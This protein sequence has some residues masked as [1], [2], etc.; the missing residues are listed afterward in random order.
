LTPR[1][2]QLAVALAALAAAL[3][4][5][6]GI[7]VA[8]V[9]ATLG[10]A[11]RSVVAPVLLAR[12]AVAAFAAMLLIFLAALVFR[13]LF[14]RY[15]DAPAELLDQVRV[16]M[17]G[18]I[19]RELPERGSSANRGLAQAIAMLL[20]ERNRLRDDMARRVAEA[21]HDI[22]QER[23]RL[24]ALMSELEQS[25]VVCNLEGRILLY[26]NGARELF[27]T[28]ADS[29]VHGSPTGLI[30]LGRSIHA[31]ID[32]EIIAHALHGILS[33]LRDGARSPSSEF[34]T[35]TAAGHLLRVRMTAVPA[36]DG[37]GAGGHSG[38]PAGDPEG[39]LD[40]FVLMIDD[41]TRTFELDSQRDDLL[42]R[43]TEG[44]RASLANLQAAVEMLEL[45]DLDAP[46][47]ER[48]IAVI[49]EEVISL[50]GRVQA[51]AADVALETSTR[52]PLEDMR[53]TEF[54]AA[55]GRHIEA[56]QR[57]VR[58]EAG[59]VDP[60]LWLRVDSFAL[61]QALGYLAGRLHRDC[62]VRTLRLRITA[63]RPRVRLDLAWSGAVPASTSIASWQGDAMRTAGGRLPISVSDVVGRH[64][65]EFWFEREPAG[66]GGL[67]RFLLPLAD[68]RDEASAAPP[69]SL[70]ARP[71]FYDFGLFRRSAQSRQLDDRGLADLSYTVFDTETTGLDPS[72]GDEI[73]QIGATRIVNGKL[74]QSECFNQLIDP[75]R[76]V[77]AASSRI[78]GLTLDMLRGKPTFREVLP[79]F[80]AFASD[81]VLVGHNAAFDM[82]FLELKQAAAGVRFDHAVLDTLL[83][84]ALVHPDHRSHGLEEIAMRLDIAVAKRHD[85]LADA[86]LTAEIFLRLLPLLQNLG[87]RTLRQARAAALSTYYGRLRY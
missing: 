37:G 47:R 38:D 42:R 22:E 44:S 48:F 4:L 2:K 39:D 23:S 16:L 78:H 19:R 34:A 7:I 52:W 5:A 50:A 45:P 86:L 64:G 41:I 51:A 21:S 71:E 61:L 12:A 25:V 18:D 66:P 67:F 33:R 83:L 36:L 28:S 35:T 60:S 73:I 17:H 30:G 29:M 84:A 31:V 75:Q 80:H 9:W 57:G 26:N 68:E 43:L 32:R 46:Q 40:G 82:R 11:E 13:R 49:H 1:D 8:A 74:L 63:A 85:A 10:P 65:G 6:A 24:A 14:E 15:V 77:A 54:L 59:D 3:L 55:A 53:G 70:E 20:Q 76:P 72:G 58:I 81:T 69:Q 56:M 27:G 79:A 87:I 62:E